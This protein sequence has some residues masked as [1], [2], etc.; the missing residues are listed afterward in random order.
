MDGKV[1]VEVS[2]KRNRIA[3]LYYVTSSI[4]DSLNTSVQRVSF[5]WVAHDTFST[6]TEN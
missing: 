2:G 3:A 6:T 1:V 4:E 5:K